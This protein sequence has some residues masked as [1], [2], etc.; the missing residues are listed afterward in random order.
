MKMLPA[1]SNAA[2][3]WREDCPR[4]S[5]QD[6]GRKDN[7]QGGC[8]RDGHCAYRQTAS[9]ADNEPALKMSSIDQ[10]PD[11]RMQG[12]ADEPAHRQH[13]ANRCLI[14]IRLRQQEHPHIGPQT[15]ADISEEEVQ[16]IERAEVPQR[17]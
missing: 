15:A 13:R 4:H 14:P 5:H 9:A 2:F 12:D 6:V 11:R 10:R 7:R 16:P 17:T 1:R 3:R 8:P